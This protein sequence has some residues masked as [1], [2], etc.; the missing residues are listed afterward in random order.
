[1]RIISKILPPAVPETV[2]SEIPDVDLRE[3]LFLDIETTGIR[4]AQSRVF[5]IGCA[6]SRPDG[7]Q[8]T[9]WFD[10]T[11][12]EERAVL[13]SFLVF[14]E[15][16]KVII[17]YNGN[18]FDLPFLRARIEECGLTSQAG[19]FLSMESMDLY[20]FISPYRHLLGLPDYRQ[21]TLEAALSPGRAG[22]EG[23]IS[24]DAAGAGRTSSMEGDAPAETEGAKSGKEKTSSTAAAADAG[25]ARFTDGRELT[26]AYKK[27]VSIP[28]AGLLDRLVLHNEANVAGLLALLPLS[29]FSLLEDLQI[30]V[31]RAQANYY[32]DVE[33]NRAEEL[34]VR[35]ELPFSL[36]LPVYAGLDHCYLKIEG[37][38][39]ILKIPLYTCTMKYFYSN[40]Q[41]Y[42]YLPAED[43][44]I[45]KYI[46]SYV[47]R[48]RR[49]QAR[50]ETCYTKKE[51]TYLPQWDLYRTPFFKRSYEEKE[52]FFE[53][54][55]DFKRDRKALSD[56]VS[57]V[58]AHII[59]RK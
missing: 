37:P 7:W 30:R 6:A 18:R 10:D 3:A 1:M 33:G 34:F 55:D 48:S 13:T 16:F 44:A 28:S 57:Y 15:S 45:H 49:V 26:E 41:D 19:H 40:Y 8:L 52:I 47:D 25:R 23:G 46:S 53:F 36:P 35:F 24:S 12:L 59:A 56:Y 14:A 58:L 43:M 50:P 29:R 54:V 38:E 11:G 39:G 31:R 20:G 4:R 51:S 5:L 17:N 42:Y 22:S 21:Q 9:Q 2:L 27:Y 32:T